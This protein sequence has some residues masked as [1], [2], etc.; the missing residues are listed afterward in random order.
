MHKFF[1]S[2]LFALIA[3]FL[4]GVGDAAAQLTCGSAAGTRENENP[5]LS[6]CLG[7]Q[8]ADRFV[9][10]APN[11]FECSLCIEGIP[12]GTGVF[13][14]LVEYSYNNENFCGTETQC[15]AV[16]GM[17]ADGTTCPEPAAEY[18]QACYNH[19]FEMPIAT[20]V[21]DTSAT[22]PAGSCRAALPSDQ[23]ICMTIDPDPTIGVTPMQQP[24]HFTSVLDGA[25]AP[26]LNCGARNEYTVLPETQSIGPSVG[27]C[28]TESSCR[29]SGFFPDGTSNE[30]RLARNNEDCAGISQ[31]TP[32]FVEHELGNN[33]RARM[34]GDCPQGQILTSGVCEA[35]DMPEVPNTERTACICPVMTHE[36]INGEC[37]ARCDD[38]EERLNGVCTARC[39]GNE[40]R[41]NGVCTAPCAPDQRRNAGGTCEARCP[42]NQM[43]DADTGM[44]HGLTRDDCNNNQIFLGAGVCG[45]CPRDQMPNEQK[46]A[47]VCRNEAEERFADGEC[48][49]CPPNR[50]LNSQRTACVCPASTPEEINGACVARC[51]TTQ[52]RNTDGM[53]EDCPPGQFGRADNTCSANCG[54]NEMPGD[55]GNCVCADDLEPF[56]GECVTRCRMTE[57]RGADGICAECGM[58]QMPNA[59]GTACACAGE[60]R[61]IAV[62]NEPLDCRLPCAPSQTRDDDTRECR[63]LEP[64]DCPNTQI[65]TNG[66]CEGC[67]QNQV[68][69]AD[70]MCECA[71]AFDNL[72]TETE[73]NCV[74]ECARGNE[75]VGETCE[76]ACA[77]TERRNSDGMCVMQ[78][79]ASSESDSSDGAVALAAVPVVLIGGYWLLGGFRYVDPAYDFSYSGEN[80]NFHY[81]GNAGFNLRHGGLRSYASAVQSNGESVG[82]RSG[83]SYER[84]YLSLTYAAVEFD[85][86]YLYD[87]GASVKAE[88][89]LWTISPAAAAEL[90]YQTGEESWNSEA[91]AG[92][93]AAWSA[94]RWIVKAQSAFAGDNG[95]RLDVELKF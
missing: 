4:G 22:P 87:L 19:N 94:H 54:N 37:I 42:N 56:G 17:R 1:S 69:G 59:G 61:N 3:A 39:T 28:S 27:L 57:I 52:I 55:D 43:Y 9:V 23:N 65:L 93:K 84:D 81:T 89:G 82:Y 24:G 60:H 12:C 45:A 7:V 6:S 26:N 47:C 14:G 30:C 44:C 80:E 77:R 83:I 41:L 71:D 95:H 58:N 13:S 73:L 50:V 79:Q 64:E 75:R 85:R 66:M 21:F 91:S 86:E 5:H 48:R 10:T 68:R 90:Q 36:E 35:C 32:M 74:A 46:T 15:N 11:L 8:A 2:A 20:A 72:G 33:C 53:C 62:A 18:H 67:G 40:E 49:S 51:A 92:I 38:S 29:G 63:L 16:M 31:A 34:A 88:F 78:T 76:P 70:N 25:C